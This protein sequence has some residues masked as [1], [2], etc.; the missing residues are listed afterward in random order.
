MGGE[1]LVVV[2]RRQ[3]A[4]VVAK[5]HGLLQAH[6][7]GI[8]EAA[9][10]HHQ[11]Q[12]DVHDADL[13]VV[14]GGKPLGPQVAPQLVAGQCRQH[15]HTPYR[16]HGKGSQND[17]IM[18]RNRVPGQTSEYEFGQVQVFKH[19]RHLLRQYSGKQA[20]SWWPPC[21]AWPAW[22]SCP[23]SLASC[24][25]WPLWYIMSS[26]HTVPGSTQRLRMAW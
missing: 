20:Y 11:T 3:V 25:P 8:G 14:D 19:G 12:D 6:H 15:G 21:W 17:R 22:A 13:L 16:H 10:Q 26:M 7:D 24:L 18:E 9:Q 1:D 4:H 5:G 23:V 2:V